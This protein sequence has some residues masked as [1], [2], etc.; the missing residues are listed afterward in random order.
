MGEARKGK[1]YECPGTSQDSRY[2]AAGRKHS[3][4]ELLIADFGVL[5]EV[6]LV[7]NNLLPQIIEERHIGKKQA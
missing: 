7:I 3:S 1:A 6:D 2:L 4:S 5:G